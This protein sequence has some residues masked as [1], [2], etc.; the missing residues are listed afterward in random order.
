MAIMDYLPFV[1]NAEKTVIGTN[2]G[3]WGDGDFSPDTPQSLVA[4]NTTGY[5]DLPL[6]TK[7]RNPVFAINGRGALP[8]FTPTCAA[9]GLSSPFQEQLQPCDLAA[10]GDGAGKEVFNVEAGLSY[11]MR[12]VAAMF[13]T[14]GFIFFAIEKHDFKV[15][16]VDG[17]PVKPFT[18]TSLALMGG[19]TYDIILDADQPVA[20]Y[21]LTITGAGPPSGWTLHYRTAPDAA[22]QTSFPFREWAGGHVALPL[23]A[24]PCLALRGRRH[25]HRHC[26]AMRSPRHMPLLLCCHCPELVSTNSRRHRRRWASRSHQGA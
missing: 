18:V 26:P 5:P 6:P 11:R 10:C 8:Q 9:M 1:S 24:L 14:E 7:N 22:P 2:N 15:V 20:N 13:M 16:A 19:E 17:Q 12:I 23:F 21:W 3:L 4:K 25:R